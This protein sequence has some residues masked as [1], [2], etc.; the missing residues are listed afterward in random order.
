MWRQCGEVGILLTFGF[1]LLAS[2]QQDLEEELQSENEDLVMEVEGNETD[3]VE[4]EMVGQD[5]LEDLHLEVGRRLLVEGGLEVTL[6]RAGQR[7]RWKAVNGDLVAIQYE[8]RVEGEE[9]RV[10]HATELRQPFVFVVRAE[11]LRS[12]FDRTDKL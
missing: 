11:Q 2:G 10:F 7:C 9:G 1:L 5:E 4:E 6:L 3:S 8:G 12:N